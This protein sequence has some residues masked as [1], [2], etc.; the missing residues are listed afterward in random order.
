MRP[1]HGF[2]IR[3]KVGVLGISALL[4]HF[5]FGDFL[6]IP[7]HRERPTLLHGDVLIVEWGTPITRSADDCI[8]N[9]L[10]VLAVFTGP[11]FR[12][13]AGCAHQ[14]EIAYLVSV[15][16]IARN[17]VWDA[18]IDL[19]CACGKPAAAKGALFPILRHKLLLGLL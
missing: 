10:P 2:G 14:H 13:I 16:G 6:A 9:A 8:V 15:G 19:K 12:A 1:Q 4:E 17:L 11:T 5:V 7:L 18:M 3:G